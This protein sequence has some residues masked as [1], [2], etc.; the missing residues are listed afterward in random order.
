MLADVIDHAI[1]PL[2]VFEPTFPSHRVGG[3]PGARAVR[4]GCPA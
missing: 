1:D 2:L 3:S 4:S